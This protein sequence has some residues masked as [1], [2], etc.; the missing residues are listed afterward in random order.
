MTYSMVLL[1]GILT[2]GGVFVLLAPVIF[3]ETRRIRELD[4]RL[5]LARQEAILAVP[6]SGAAGMAASP[7]HFLGPTLVRGASMLVPI[8]TSEREKLARALRRAG[9]ARQEALSL[10]LSSKLAGSLAGASLFAVTAAVAGPVGA[11]FSPGV[12]IAFGGLAGFVIGGIVPEY[13]VRSLVSRRRRRMA[14]ALPDALD[15][16]VMC[17]ETGLTFERALATV[18]DALMPLEPNLAREFRLIEAE[19]RVGSNRRSVLQ[20]Y[21]ERTDV[22]GLRDMTMSLIQGDRYGTPLAQSLKNIAA[23]ERVQRTARIEAWASR[24][25]VLMSLPMLVLVIPGTMLLVAGPAFLTAIRSL[26]G[27]TGLGGG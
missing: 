3:Q 25:P 14:A 5:T 8:G 22:E 9:F 15:L 18:A 10:F 7:L 26:S 16:M 20:A 11:L 1:A 17:V 19:L 12:L 24:L 6:G 27:I 13:V 2:S 4:R 23:G 21:Q